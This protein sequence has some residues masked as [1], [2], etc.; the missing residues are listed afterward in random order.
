[1]EKFVVAG[2]DDQRAGGTRY[3]DLPLHRHVSGSLR[4]NSVAGETPATTGETPVL[5]ISYA[6]RQ[7]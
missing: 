5:P 7:M 2:C 4:E 1:M 3:P 6:A